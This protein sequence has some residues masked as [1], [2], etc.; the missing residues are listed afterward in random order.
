SLTVDEQEILHGIVGLK[1]VQESIVVDIRCHGSKPLTEGVRN[2]SRSAHVLERAVSVVA[3][4]PARAGV[5]DAGNAVKRV[6]PVL[7]LLTAA[8]VCEIRSAHSEVRII[9]ELWDEEIEPAV[10]I[11]VKP[12]CASG[13]AGSKNTCLL[14]D[15]LEAAIAP[16]VVKVGSIESGDVDV[17]IAV[18]V[19]ISCGDSHSEESFLE[20]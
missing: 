5:E 2:A 1:N 13:P 17:R 12:E 11:V 7:P 4:K 15:F 9:D 10:V 8:A 14:R 19:I 6:G 20:S 16:I 18:A 3:E